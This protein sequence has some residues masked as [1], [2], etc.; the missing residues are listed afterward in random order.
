MHRKLRT[1]EWA[2]FLTLI[3]IWSRKYYSLNFPVISRSLKVPL[4]YRCMEG[5]L[6]HGSATQ[7]KFRFLKRISLL[8][9]S[10]LQ[11]TKCLSPGFFKKQKK[12]PKHFDSI[13]FLIYSSVYTQTLGIK[14]T[15]KLATMLL[16]LYF[17]HNSWK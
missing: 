5:H 6:L 9:I 12:M 3:L 1:V 2:I 7:C 14:T 10:L 17:R 15:M 4:F 11:E 16:S 13:R 8:F